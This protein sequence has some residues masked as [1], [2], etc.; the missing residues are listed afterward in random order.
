MNQDTG[1]LHPKSNGSVCKAATELMPRKR[2]NYTL[3]TR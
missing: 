3:Q 2:K 1:S